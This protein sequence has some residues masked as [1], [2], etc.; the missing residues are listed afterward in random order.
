[1]MRE[2]EKAGKA[3]DCDSSLTSMK[4]RRKE[5]TKEERS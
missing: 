4:D 1:M 5:E 3:S 2:V